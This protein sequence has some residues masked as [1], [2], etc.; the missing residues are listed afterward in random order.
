MSPACVQ[1]EAYLR[2]AGVEVQYESCTSMANTP[3]EVLPVLEVGMEVVS[4]KVDNDVDG[5]QSAKAI[6][7]FLRSKGIDLDSKFVGEQFADLVA[8]TSLIETQIVPALKKAMWL[9]S[10]SFQRICRDIYNQAHPFPLNYVVPLLHRERIRRE[11]KNVPNHDQIYEQAAHALE[12]I[13]ERLKNMGDASFFLGHHPSSLDA[14]LF[15]VL[16]FL[17]NTPLCP[18][19]LRTR[20]ERYPQLQTYVANL[21]EQY[22]QGQNENSAYR[23]QQGDAKGWSEEAKGKSKSESQS[24]LRPLKWYKGSKEWLIIVG[25]ALSLYLIWGTQIVSFSHGDM[26]HLLGD[27]ED[28]DED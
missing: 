18:P 5:Y 9:E 16:I 26:E 23:S 12:A 17:Q 7:Q 6:I 21:L 11:L 24:A 8:F 4:G 20:L 10:N 14:Q 25:A 19:I 3:G 2:F 22:F 1:A 15:S 28:E 13:G 27:D